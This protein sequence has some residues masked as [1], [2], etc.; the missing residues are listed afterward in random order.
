MSTSI[1]Y[2]D[3]FD[4]SWK[5]ILFRPDYKSQSGELNEL[6]SLLNYQYTKAYDFL[7]SNYRIISGL[8]IT[9]DSFTSFGYKCKLSAG[10]LF[11]IINDKGYFVNVPDNYFEFAYN[12]TVKIGININFNYLQDTID[13]LKDPLTGGT[14][15][16]DLG[17]HR[18]VISTNLVIDQD[19]FP[20]GVI[21]GRDIGEYP[22][23]FY[24]TPSGY[25]L[26]YD[27]N[28]IP[29][30]VSDYLALRLYEESGNF[31]ATGLELAMSS[32]TSFTI[33]SGEAYIN[34]YSVK[35]PYP[36]SYN[37]PIG[38]YNLNPF[39]FYLTSSG[40]IVVNNSPPK[41]QYNSI[42][43]GI[44]QYNTSVGS[45]FSI[46]TKKRSLINSEVELLINQSKTNINNFETFLLNDSLTNDNVNNPTSLTGFLIDPFI[47]L[48]GS[49]INALNYSAS[50][51]PN[52]GILRPGF[53]ATTINF[54]NLTA[55]NL[56]FTKVVTNGGNPYYFIPTTNQNI[57]INQ[58]RATSFFTLNNVSSTASISV[59]PP[60]G[61]ADSTTTTFTNIS[62]IAPLN[63]YLLSNNTNVIPTVTSTLSTILVTVNGVGFNSL[64]DNLAITFGN[65]AITNFT[66][67]TGSQGSTVSTIMADIAGNISLSFN[68]PSNLL[69]KD[70]II[71]VSNTTTTATC[72]F[73]SQPSTLLNYDYI[74]N[75]AQTFTIDTPIIVSQVNLAINQIPTFTSTS[76]DIALVTITTTD[77]NGNPTNNILGQG[78][79]N[80]ININTSADGSAYSTVTFNI[81]IVLPSAGQYALVISSL[82][83]SQT[84]NIYFADSTQQSLNSTSITGNQ[85]LIGGNLLTC[86]SGV[87]TNQPNQ[88]LTFQLLQA[89][90][91]TTNGEA[92]FTITNPIANINSINS[93]IVSITP[94]DTQVNYLYQNNLGN[95][96]PLNSSQPIQG[97]T[98]TLN[99]KLVLSGNSTLFPIVLLNQSNFTIYNNSTDSVWVSKTFQYNN[100][101][102]TNVEI[103]FQYYQPKGTNINISFTSNNGQTWEGLTQGDSTS[104]NPAIPLYS[105]T[106][107]SNNLTP[108]V[109]NTDVNGNTSQILRTSIA[110]RIE[111]I[112]NDA[113]II[114]Y[115]MQM[116]GVLY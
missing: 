28:Y 88:D 17:A 81:P 69:L 13:Y 31:I 63:A 105:A 92:T 53:T 4:P 82:I 57:V 90:P 86:I 42:L 5:K 96:V 11:I 46:G 14:L 49:D 112:T 98:N 9:L 85:P 107:S 27:S 8:Q 65:I 99:V 87:W 77:T 108:T 109:N 30:V 68:V 16:G 83:P 38:G 2:I 7:F 43:I 75:L 95:W 59:N 15:C 19:S 62:N 100:S 44:V 113:S 94:S 80:L 104:V 36:F 71:Q 64:E 54:N 74:G 21:L 115:V 101:G 79:L 51:V 32:S 33:S 20:I 35:L 10:K 116:K 23:I 12:S 56:L 24:F 110:I 18:L 97:D 66:V 50:I 34:G 26:Q 61:I 29:G 39:S 106:W 6:Q 1:N 114:P 84:I 91:S 22:Y 72:S 76:L 93:S 55:S 25:S 3:R 89:V 67:I 70:Y 47:N 58:N 37:L 78:T 45:Y 52:Y 41:E 48:N 103:N 102:Y 40:T 111:F 73:R 60:N